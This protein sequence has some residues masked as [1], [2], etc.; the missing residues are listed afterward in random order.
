MKRFLRR[1]VVAILLL[2][3]GCVIFFRIVSH[4]YWSSM[5]DAEVRHALRSWG[6]ETN[7]YISP[8]FQRREAW[9]EAGEAIRW[10]KQVGHGGQIE[11]PDGWR[12]L[13]QRE[14]ERLVDFLGSR[15]KSPGFCR[16]YS[17]D[18]ERRQ[19]ISPKADYV[20]GTL[21]PSG[22]LKLGKTSVLGTPPMANNAQRVLRKE[23]SDVEN[24]TTF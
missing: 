21:F 2:F 23:E 14:Q 19:I 12:V 18:S 4:Y 8:S 5:N 3:L 15:P 11:V 1:L 17:S 13:T 20:L 9:F 16:V 22:E 10:A 7:V 6:N 24:S